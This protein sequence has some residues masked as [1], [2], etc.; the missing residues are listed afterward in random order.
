MVDIT[1]RHTSSC[2]EANEAEILSVK[3][4]CRSCVPPSAAAR[5]SDE[6]HDKNLLLSNSLHSRYSRA[7]GDTGSPVSIYV[8][9][10]DWPT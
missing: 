10:L 5:S 3:S 4:T 6:Y 8:Y 7:Y 1:L 9:T 2:G